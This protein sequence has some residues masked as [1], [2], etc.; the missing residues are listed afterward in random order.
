[1]DYNKIVD[2]LANN[3]VKIN[4]E[5]KILLLLS[6]LL[7][8]FENFKDVLLYCKEDTITLEEVQSAIKKNLPSSKTKWMIV[9]KA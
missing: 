9:V 8:F 2:N 4:D 6:F 1:M 3:Y 7:K 5:D